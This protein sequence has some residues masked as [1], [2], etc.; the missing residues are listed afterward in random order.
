MLNQGANYTDYIATILGMVH[1][2]PHHKRIIIHTVSAPSIFHAHAIKAYN[3]LVFQSFTL[4][5]LTEKLN[6]N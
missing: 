5:T 4:V 1:P 3:R 6:G 2:I